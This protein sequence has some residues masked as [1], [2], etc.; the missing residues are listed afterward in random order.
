MIGTALFGGSARGDGTWGFSPGGWISSIVGALIVLWAYL[1]ISGRAAHRR[2]AAVP[3]HQATVGFGA[4]IRRSRRAKGHRHERE[5][6]RKG[7]C[8]EGGRIPVSPN[9][10]SASAQSATPAVPPSCRKR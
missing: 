8:R 9:R 4:A 1:A 3:A 5:R 2:L 7:E 10:S 6:C